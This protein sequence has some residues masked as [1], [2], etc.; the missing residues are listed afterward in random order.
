MAFVDGLMEV[1]N[2]LELVAFVD[3]LMEVD[4]V[5]DLVDLVLDTKF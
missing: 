5:L 4:N 3:G 1:D 2:V